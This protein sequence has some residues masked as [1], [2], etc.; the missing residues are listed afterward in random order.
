MKLTIL[1]NGQFWEGVVE[2]NYEGC[3]K[4]GKHI[5]GSE[6]KDPEVLNFV[7]HSALK[8]LENTTSSIEVNIAEEKRVNPK[9]LAR[10]VA[11]ESVRGV[12]TMAQEVIQRELETRK[13]EKKVTSKAQKEAEKEQKRL[14]AQQKAKARHR[15]KG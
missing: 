6:P 9:R 7:I 2:V 12:S 15:G 8:I 13:K 1:F 5:F 10:E 4:A 3:F 14:I 11:K